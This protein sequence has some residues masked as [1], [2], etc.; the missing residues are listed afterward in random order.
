M[1]SRRQFLHWGAWSAAAGTA[2]LAGCANPGSAESAPGPGSASPAGSFP[3]TVKHAYGTTTVPAVP[4]RVVSVG[5]TEQDPLL[6]LGVIPVAVTEWYGNQP[7]ATWPWAL[8]RFGTSKPTVL[9]TADGFQFERIAGLAPDLIIGTNSGMTK[10]DYAKLS[11]IAPTVAHAGGYASE[12]FE[13]WWLQTQL[14]GDALGQREQAAALIAGLRRRFA[15]TAAANPQF[16][17]KKAI[18]LQGAFYEGAAIASPAGL[19]TDFLTD[20]GFVIPTEIN[21]FIKDGAQAY[22]PLE[23]LSV[24]DAADVLIWATDDPDGTVDRNKNALCQRLAAVREK[25]SV[26]TGAELA[27][28]TYFTS[29]LSLGLVLDQLVPK[30]TAVFPES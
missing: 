9:S 3:A 10:Q 25:R 1:P 8:P 14:I 13:P 21:P 4:R 29:V 17:G 7:S 24:L 27:A 28:A 26:D 22:V 30:L 15:D 2:V 11:A 12:Y 19:A 20:L 5:V 23:K 6:A 18:F 16:K